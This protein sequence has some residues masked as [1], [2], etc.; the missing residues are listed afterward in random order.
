MR[1]LHTTK[2]KFEEFF[3]DE[4]PRYAIMSHRWGPDEVS[5]QDFL[6]GRKKEGA[7]YRKIVACCNYA[8]SDRERYCRNFLL[9]KS[10]SGPF[11][12]VWIDTCCIDKTSSAELSEAINSMFE[13]YAKATICYAYLSDV[14]KSK[15]VGQT[16][17]EFRESKWFTRGWTLQELL[18]PSNL[19]ILDKNWTQIGTR[20][21][22][23]F[24]IAQVTGISR[25][26][27][28]IFWDR[29]V[30]FVSAAEKFSWVAGRETSRREDQAYYLL[31]IFGINMPLLYGEGKNAFRRLQAE[32]IRS[33]N[34][35][36]VFIW[37]S[38]R[39]MGLGG[40]KGLMPNSAK[41]YKFDHSEHHPNF[42]KIP[43]R[44]RPPYSITNQ[45]VELCVPKGLSLQQNFLFP[46]NC[47]HRGG[48]A[49][50]IKLSKI[51]SE[52]SWQRSLDP[53]LKDPKLKGS[54]HH[55]GG[56][57]FIVPIDRVWSRE[58][59]NKRGSEIIYVKPFGESES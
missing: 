1:L 38:P 14:T 36:S 24:A 50:T 19:S 5:Y 54:A 31:G 16:M 20:M 27:V 48:G 9:S 44:A 3:D 22:L 56:S 47:T 57:L 25:T 43:G 49:Y 23:D 34:D 42:N 45:G 52:G 33:S 28:T 58:D 4:V 11:Q 13:W 51:N 18:A 8:A 59:L 39:Y 21:E 40:V 30:H 17:S 6:A 15:D 7:G 53:E 26:Q 12:W 29:G 41:A 10:D 55:L 2:L 32:I 37:E 35:E 46:L